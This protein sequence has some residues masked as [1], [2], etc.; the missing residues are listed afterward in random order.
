MPGPRGQTVEGMNVDKEFKHGRFTGIRAQNSCQILPMKL[1]T[2]YGDN[3]PFSIDEAMD[4]GKVLWDLM[5]DAQRR[6]LLEY[7]C[8]HQRA[9]A[10]EHVRALCPACGRRD[11]L[12]R[13]R[14]E[15]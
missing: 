12:H 15:E 2:A 9:T 11:T 14:K 5:T 6:E 8:A 13:P 10:P 3:L 1:F 4:V 7:A